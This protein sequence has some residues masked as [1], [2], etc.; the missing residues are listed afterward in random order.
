VTLIF[1]YTTTMN[2][3]ERPEG[4]KVSCFFIATI[5]LVSFIS[6]AT[7]STELRITGVHLSKDASSILE[8]A[9]HQVIRVILESPPPTSE[10]LVRVSRLVR[11]IYGLPATAKI[12][13]FEVERTDASE[14]DQQLTVEGEKLGHHC[15]LHARTP[16]WPIRLRLSDPC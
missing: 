5:L 16:L 11:S 12:V 14:F 10:D 2:I 9:R 6:R 7:R 3:G 4:L 15:I 13:F 8:S 1:I